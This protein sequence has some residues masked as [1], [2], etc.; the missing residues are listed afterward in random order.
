MANQVIPFVTS[1]DRL[2]LEGVLFDQRSLV[3]QCGALTLAVL[4]HVLVTT[5]VRDHLAV[6]ALH[7]LIVDAVKQTA[8]VVTVSR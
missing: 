1:F 6:L 7:A 3:H 5:L 4:R 2:R 8:A